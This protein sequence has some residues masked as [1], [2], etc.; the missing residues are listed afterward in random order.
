MALVKDIIPIPRDK[1]SDIVAFWSLVGI[2]AEKKSKKHKNIS[3]I[4]EKIEECVILMSK[5]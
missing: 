4:V 1:S 2:F 3:V 5:M